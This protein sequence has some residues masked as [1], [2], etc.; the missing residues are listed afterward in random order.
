MVS[1]LYLVDLAGSEKSNNSFINKSLQNLQICIQQ[2]A[3]NNFHVPFRASK[4]TQVLRDCLGG[5]SKT[6]IVGCIRGE[7]QYLSETLQTLRFCQEA[8][9]IKT[10]ASVNIVNR[11]FEDQSSDQRAVNSQITN[12]ILEAAQ[13]RGGMENLQSKALRE[14]EQENKKLKAE[15]ML[16]S[17]QQ[18]EFT[19][20]QNKANQLRANVD[21]WL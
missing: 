7:Q 4:L 11:M 16:L 10:E 18:A 6:T 17:G 12:A 9:N 2:L 8:V 15:I 13:Q 3:R 1:K 5:S 19:A 14:L 20:D 21:L